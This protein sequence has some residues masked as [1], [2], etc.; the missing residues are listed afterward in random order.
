MPSTF[1]DPQ[2]KSPRSVHVTP[3]VQVMV[4]GYISNTI[5][6]VDSE[7]KKKLAILASMKDGVHTPVSVFYSSSTNSI[8]LG[9]DNNN[10]M[11]GFKVI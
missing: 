3:S 6:Q 7:G 2:L 11:L 5:I 10:A 4:C 1:T 8:I 9:L